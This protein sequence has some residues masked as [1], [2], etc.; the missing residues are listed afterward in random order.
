MQGGL[1]E[2]SLLTH[3]VAYKSRRRLSTWRDSAVHDVNEE[4]RPQLDAIHRGASLGIRILARRAGLRLRRLGE[5]GRS[6]SGF[7]A[8]RRGAD[9]R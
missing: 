9:P 8:I 4:W 3:G 6:D 2:S 5:Q 7:V 1:R